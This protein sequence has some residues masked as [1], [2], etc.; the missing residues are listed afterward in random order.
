[1]TT[2]ISVRLLIYL[3]QTPTAQR[4]VVV[5]DE[6]PVQTSYFIIL[7]L[8]ADL[9]PPLYSALSSAS[10]LVCFSCARVPVCRWFGVRTV[11]V[12]FSQ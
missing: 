3:Q 7:P 10:L 8:A 5:P 6:F 9:Y 4:L 1:M 2:I 12:F 11:P